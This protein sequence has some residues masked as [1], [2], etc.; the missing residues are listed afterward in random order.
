MAISLQFKEH[1]LL[2]KFALF[3]FGVTFILLTIIFWLI[4][5]LQADSQRNLALA[6]MKNFSFQLS[7]NIIKSQMNQEPMNCSAAFNSRYK[8]MLLD[9][10]GKR[11]AG[12]LI[13][14]KGFIL[15]DKSPL[16]HMGVWS[17]L[18]KDTTFPTLQKELLY[19]TMI[20][21]ILSYL[22][23]AL[24][25]YYLICLFLKPIKE[26]RERLDN[27]IKDTTH[28]LNTPITALLMCANSQSIQNPKNQERIRLSAKRVSELYKDLTYIFLED[29]NKRVETLQMG[30]VIEELISYF[31]ILAHKKEVTIST[32]LDN[33]KVAMDSEDFKRLISNLL[34]N[35]IKYNKRGGS[36]TIV[37]KNSTLT[38]SDSG[39]GIA[40]EDQ[41][42]IFDKY[43]RAT[44]EAGGFGI[45]LSIVKQICQE[46]NIKIEVDSTENIGTK[47]RLHFPPY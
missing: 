26:A 2:K 14:R 12:D 37:L 43:Y 5:N 42:R 39:I 45:G 40:K 24:L 28:E 15:E 21:F 27:F 33:S 1:Q 25:G 3:Y 19:K 35:T 34:T 22:V 31:D 30:E 32:S 9:K 46:Y 18:V 44:K 36:V 6:K 8:F 20:A 23:I 41:E 4:Y 29:K 10:E 11:I 17:I 47:F 7:S 38:I 16:G 13:D